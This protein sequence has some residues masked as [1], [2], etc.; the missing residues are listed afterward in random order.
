MELASHWLIAAGVPSSSTPRPAASSSKRVSEVVLAPVASA[1][2]PL[3]TSSLTRTELALEFKSD[4]GTK[5]GNCW[6]RPSL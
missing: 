4:C 2:C 6:L 5:N 1:N 3:I